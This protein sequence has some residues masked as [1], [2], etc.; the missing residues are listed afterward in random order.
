MIIINL[1]KKTF[2]SYNSNRGEMTSRM[3]LFAFFVR[4]WCYDM[5][6]LM[7]IM[8]AYEVFAY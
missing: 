2:I 4:P 3:L 1:I 5:L 7:I 8:A 6:E